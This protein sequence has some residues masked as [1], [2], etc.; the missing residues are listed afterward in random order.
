MISLSSMERPV[1]QR[2]CRYHDHADH[3]APANTV[4]AL[5]S[6]VS[7]HGLADFAFSHGAARAPRLAR[8]SGRSA[9]PK[10]LRLRSIGR[11]CSSPWITLTKHNSALRAIGGW[12]TAIWHALSTFLT[13]GAIGF[14][15]L[16]LPRR[17]SDF[18]PCQMPQRRTH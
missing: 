4:D 8:I 17:I 18:P 16:A 9:A 7:F 11:A 14:I 3:R 1:G 12:G 2:H 5:H 10:T 6:S 15:W 13:P